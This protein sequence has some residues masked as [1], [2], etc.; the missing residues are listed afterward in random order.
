MRKI[1]RFGV[2]AIAA[3]GI[4]VL[5]FSAASAAPSV[6]NAPDVPHSPSAIQPLSVTATGQ[7]LFVPIT[8]CRVVDTRVQVGAFSSGQ[9]RTYYVAGTTGFAPQGGHSGGCG[10]PAGAV[11]VTASLSAVS[12]QHVGYVRTWAFGG[13][14][15]SATVLNYSTVNITA[16]TT[17]PLNPGSGKNLSVK[18][19]GGPTHLVIDITGY[20][21][22]QIYG[23]FSDT[24]TLY[25]GNGTLTYYSHGS[26]GSYVVQSPRDLSGCAVVASS[27]Y[28]A[29]N[30]SAYTSGNYIYVYLTNYDGNPVDYYFHLEVSC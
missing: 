7:N 3:I 13:A 9:T 23:T 21:A 28:F 24:G 8:P 22:K 1:T 26:T 16:G 10:I 11:A 25:N 30:A 6:P 15:P 2:G 19:Y 5:G 4:A 14:E 12:P 20:Y 27:Y 29:Y 17:V 18:N